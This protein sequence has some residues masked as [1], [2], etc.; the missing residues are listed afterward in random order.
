MFALHST[1]DEE[2]GMS[3]FMLGFLLGAAIGELAMVFAYEWRGR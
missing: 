2:H 1:A 3:D